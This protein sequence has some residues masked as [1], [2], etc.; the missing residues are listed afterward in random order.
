MAFQAERAHGGANEH[1][2]IAGTVRLVARLAVP[3]L[4]GCMLKYKW[5]L[6]FSMAFQA[7]LA[8]KGAQ[9][10]LRAIEATVR[11]VAIITAQRI[12]LDPVMERAG[13]LNLLPNMTAHTE[14]IDRFTQEAGHAGAGMDFVTV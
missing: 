14:R 7:R 5:A 3:N 2:G 8:A 12:F 9:P 4:E 13:K 6:L 10:D 1:F 11:L